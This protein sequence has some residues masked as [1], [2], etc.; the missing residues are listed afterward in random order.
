MKRWAPPHLRV[1]AE[2]ERW[3]REAAEI[4]WLSPGVLNEVGAGMS[5][6]CSRKRV[7]FRAEFILLKVEDVS[8]SAIATSRMPYQE[9]G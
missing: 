2:S 5:V 8:V 7:F 4:V 6:V 1:Q 3:D 9:V